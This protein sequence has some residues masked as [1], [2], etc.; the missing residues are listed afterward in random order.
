LDNHTI[1]EL[2]RGFG[3]KDFSIST[4]DKEKTRFIYIAGKKE[5]LLALPP[6]QEKF[7]LAESKYLTV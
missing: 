6:L 2:T 4:A 7:N 3:S 5:K 1:S